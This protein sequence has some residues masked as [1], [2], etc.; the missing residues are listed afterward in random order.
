VTGEALVQRAD[1]EESVV[2]RRLKDYESQTKPI[3]DYY[4]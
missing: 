3:I 4:S 2:L 1:D